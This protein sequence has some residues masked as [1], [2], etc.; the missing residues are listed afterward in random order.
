MKSLFRA[1]GLMPFAQGPMTR[2]VN[3]IKLYEYL[4]AGL[5]VVSTP[6]PEAERFLGPVQI[7]AT[8]SQ[9]A[10]ACDSA[11]ARGD[12]EM[13]RT[14]SGVVKNESW[15]SKVE[16]ISEWIEMSQGRSAGPVSM[17]IGEVVGPVASGADGPVSLRRGT[18]SPS[19]P[20]QS[21]YV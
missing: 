9:F 8:A 11:L 17:P 12:P 1:A 16:L 4:A 5:P 13:R 19:L 2:H 15:T 14:I 21:S 20:V 3:P 10:A 7:A 6:L 18:P